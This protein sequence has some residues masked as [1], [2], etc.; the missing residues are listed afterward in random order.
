MSGFEPG[1]GCWGSLTQNSLL[2]SWVLF[3][4]DMGN[5]RQAQL[6][7]SSSTYACIA[8][9]CRT[10][11]NFHFPVCPE[12]LLGQPHRVH[13]PGALSR[14]SWPP[15]SLAAYRVRRSPIESSQC[16]WSPIESS[17]CPS[18]RRVQ[19]STFSSTCTFPVPL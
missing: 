2:R 1:N 15:R 17:L 11:E 14:L 16:P 8:D 18:M 9:T 19:E 12:T 4:W 5:T 7:H 6:G 13:Q 3:S 10:P